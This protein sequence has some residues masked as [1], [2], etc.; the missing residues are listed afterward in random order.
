VAFTEL[1][2]TAK[3][4]ENFGLYTTPLMTNNWNKAYENESV[5]TNR[6]S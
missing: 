3:E 6:M 4:A 1:D 5:Q 2:L